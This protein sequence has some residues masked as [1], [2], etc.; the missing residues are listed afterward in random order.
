M[1]KRTRGI[2]LLAAGFV[3]LFAAVAL[4]WPTTT[5][6]VWPARPPPPS[7]QELEADPAPPAITEEVTITTPEGYELLGAVH[8]PS[9]GYLSA[10]AGHVGR[11]AAGRQRPAAIPAA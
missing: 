8:I 9:A 10:G 11:S 7:L 5:A 6:T 2:L 1:N 4:Y 3:M